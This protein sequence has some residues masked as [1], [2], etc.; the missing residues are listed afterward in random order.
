MAKKA[1]L[2]KAKQKRQ[3]LIAIVGA[4]RSFGRAVA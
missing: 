2:A 4:A 1:D 3:K